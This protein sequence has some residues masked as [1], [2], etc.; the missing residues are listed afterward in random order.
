MRIKNIIGLMAVSAMPFV[1]CDP[2]QDINEALD[3]KAEADKN[4]GN[5]NVQK[6]LNYELT[7]ADYTSISKKA[8]AA[9][10]NAQDSTYAKA[11]GTQGAFNQYITPQ[12]YLPDLMKSLYPG[13]GNGSS[14]MVTLNTVTVAPELVQSLCGIP[15]HELDDEHYVEDHYDWFTPDHAISSH[16][17]TILGQH[18]EAPVANQL[19]L[20]NYN[21]SEEGPRVEE[22][23]SPCFA[24]NFDGG[25]FT[26]KEPADKNGWTQYWVKGTNF[27]WKT[28]TNGDGM[29][30]QFSSYGSKE[31]DETW[32]ISPEV[33]LTNIADGQLSFGV[34]YSYQ[35]AGHK[36]LS[37]WISSN[38]TEGDVT[39]AE[40][41]DIT[42]RFSYA[43][44]DNK[45]YH[46]AGSASLEDF[47]GKKIRA[48]FVYTGSD[49]SS[50]AMTTTVL[51]D[52]I[53]ISTVQT[54]VIPQAEV[55][56][57]HAVYQYNGSAWKEF[58][59]GKLSDEATSN[60]SVYA[61]HPEDYDEMGTSGP[62]KNNNFSSSL[63]PHNYIPQFL[64]SKNPYAQVGEQ[65][66]VVYQFVNSSKEVVNEAALYTLDAN[67]VWQPESTLTAV[68]E[69]YLNIGSA[70][71]FDPTITFTML[72][73][74]YQAIVN[75]VADNKGEK[76]LDQRY[77]AKKN[78]EMWCG[79]SA[80]YKNMDFTI[81]LRRG[82]SAD[83][84]GTL[85]GLNDEQAYALFQERIKNDGLPAVLKARYP[86]APAMTS[87]VTQYY[88]VVYLVYP[89]RAYYMMK[90]EG[91]GG[92]EFKYVEG[93]IKQ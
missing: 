41:V 40:W 22:L 11:V 93:P 45:T 19:V 56:D 48:A 33:D 92:G 35:V 23:R 61:L 52:D 79:A 21:Y 43:D 38:Y 7:A 51:I 29:G 57:K 12:P 8:L 91:L 17:A 54:T 20:V 76:W 15:T 84:E 90:Y 31:E 53:E 87:G 50:P 59:S 1:S 73:A 72:E 36:P 67:R 64:A 71:V 2:M 42:S 49:I 16:V 18:I 68:T 65:K 70:W 69:Q 5:S 66:V 9:A 82:A 13:L 24:E 4:G 39:T 60:T 26:D 46:S 58:T 28:R 3:K 74:D 62:G 81:A 10:T 75:W 44:Q 47:A 30:A 85:T 88:Q 77:L 89:E 80:Y 55:V 14:V 63:L 34:K 86:D 6:T 25:A 27:Q 37:V 32:L 83:P 78:A